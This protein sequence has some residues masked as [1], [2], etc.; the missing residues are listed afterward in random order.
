MGSVPNEYA[1]WVAAHGGSRPIRKILI[2]NNGRAC[3]AARRIR[4][5]GDS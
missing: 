5:A 2:A 1:D 3:A 4:A